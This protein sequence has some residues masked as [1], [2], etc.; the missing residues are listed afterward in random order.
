MPTSPSDKMTTSWSFHLNQRSNTLLAGLLVGGAHI[1]LLLARLL[2]GKAREG[3]DSTARLL[4]TSALLM[5]Q[6][7]SIL[8]MMQ[9]RLYLK[10]FRELALLLCPLVLASVFAALE[11][12][13]LT[14]SSANITIS[15]RLIVTI[16]LGAG[17]F[18]LLF[19]VLLNLL[20]LSGDFSGR[21]Q[22]EL[23]RALSN[24]AA[25]FTLQV[26]LL[27]LVLLFLGY[28]FVQGWRD[29]AAVHL[30]LLFFIARM[31]YLLKLFQ[32]RW[33]EVAE[34]ELAADSEPQIAGG[35]E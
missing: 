19:T 8:L 13:S 34:I 33:K 12:A 18:S 6:P 14:S 21:K 29:L 10:V 27:A 31:T 25:A 20:V 2:P 15:G 7:R 3:L 4:K 22:D 9:P 30:S 32:L 23:Q 1:L 26:M 11:R 28:L 35:R 24:Q 16:I 17:I 5:M